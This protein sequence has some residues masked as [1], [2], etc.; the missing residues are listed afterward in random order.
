MRISKLAKFHLKN[1]KLKLSKNSMRYVK[2]IWGHIIS[3]TLPR[4]TNKTIRDVKDTWF[5]W[6][7]NLLKRKFLK[8]IG[9]F[10]NNKFKI[11]M[12]QKRDTSDSHWSV[13]VLFTIRLEKWLVCWQKYLSRILKVKKLSNKHINLENLI[14]T[15]LQGKAY[16]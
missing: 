1:N 11:E 12:F 3:I 7:H 4:D 9:I 16:I 14:F 10:T 6:K 5:R 13:K 2:F 15:W 8:G